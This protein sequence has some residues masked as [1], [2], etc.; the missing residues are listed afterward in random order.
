MSGDPNGYPVGL[1]IVVGRGHMGR[2]REHS[3]SRVGCIGH[4]TKEDTVKVRSS[5][6]SLKRQV[7]SVVVR[8]HGKVYVI[9]KL[10]PRWKARQG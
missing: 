7:G 2:R 4:R 5:L 6:K 9:N 8:R 1:A 3:R 10:N